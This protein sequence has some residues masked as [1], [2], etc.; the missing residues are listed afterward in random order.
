MAGAARFEAEAAKAQAASADAP[1][2]PPRIAHTGGVI[3]SNKPEAMRRFILRLLRSGK[4]PTAEQRR[5]A[6]NL[7]LVLEELEAEAK[8]EAALAR[9]AEKERLRERLRA[10]EASRGRSRATRGASGGGRGGGRARGRGRARGAARAGAGTPPALPI[11]DNRIVIRFVVVAGKR[12]AAE[13]GGSGK[14]T[15]AAKRRK[16]DEELSSLG[17]QSNPL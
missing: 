15:E 9:E 5:T 16:L 14:E 17:P 3:T 13:V 7:G 6:A 10:A 1:S 2:K 11:H 4:T 8:D 12:G